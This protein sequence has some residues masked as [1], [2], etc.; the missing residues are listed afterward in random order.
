MCKGLCWQWH[1]KKMFLQVDVWDHARSEPVSSFQWGAESALSVRFNPV[2]FTFASCLMLLLLP[3]LAAHQPG[4]PRLTASMRLCKIVII[5]PPAEMKHFLRYL[6]SRQH[7]YGSHHCFRKRH[8]PVELGGQRSS[9]VMLV[10]SK[11]WEML[12]RLWHHNP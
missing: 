10:D 5:F 2:G 1:D 9:T 11:L 12:L 8:P 3:N 4:V 7:N 6:W